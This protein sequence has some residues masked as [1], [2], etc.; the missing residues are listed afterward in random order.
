MQGWSLALGWIW[1]GDA[2]EIRGKSGFVGFLFCF[3]AF[4]AWGDGRW[5]V[6]RV[7]SYGIE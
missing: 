3:F 4:G 1:A 5:V 6:S 7:F 2:E